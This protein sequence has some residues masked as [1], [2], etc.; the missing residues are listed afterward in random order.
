MLD[1]FLNKGYVKM[2]EDGTVERT[3]SCPKNIVMQEDENGIIQ[4]YFKY[5]NKLIPITDEYYEDN[6]IS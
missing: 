2:E 3:P 5:I 6:S 4:F 1:W